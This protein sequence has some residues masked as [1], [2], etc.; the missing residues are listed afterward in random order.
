MNSLKWWIEGKEMTSSKTGG[1]KIY[2]E[3]EEGKKGDE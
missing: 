1:E 3:M 2:E